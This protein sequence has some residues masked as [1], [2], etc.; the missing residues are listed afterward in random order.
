MRR[1]FLP[2]S[3]GCGVCRVGRVVGSYCLNVH[4][5]ERC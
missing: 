5:S 3:D 1:F 2:M 4:V